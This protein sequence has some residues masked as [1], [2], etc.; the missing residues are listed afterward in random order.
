MIFIAITAAVGPAHGSKVV[1]AAS[2]AER[3]AFHLDL[4]LDPD[5][6]DDQVG[7]SVSRGASWFSIFDELGLVV[8]HRRIGCSL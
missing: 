7:F 2:G 6:L 5:F 4:E 8:I 3:K 1:R